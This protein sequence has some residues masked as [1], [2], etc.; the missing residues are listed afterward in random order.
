MNKL[1]PSPARNLSARPPMDP[2]SPIIQQRARQT[3]SQ[4]PNQDINPSYPTHRPRLY[5]LSLSS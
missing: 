4:R 1:A 5:L 3:A 2:P